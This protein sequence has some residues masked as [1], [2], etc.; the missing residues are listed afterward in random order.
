M[1]RSSCHIYL[2]GVHAELQNLRCIFLY[3]E[4]ESD[5]GT[6]RHMLF[7]PSSLWICQERQ[8]SPVFRMHSLI[9]SIVSCSWR[10]ISL[11]VMFRQA[12]Y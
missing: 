9:A 6:L 11:L 12:A 4:T 1:M 10:N 8:Q 3:P 2:A 7:E 5:W